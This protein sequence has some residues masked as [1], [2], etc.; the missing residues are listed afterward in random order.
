M[1]GYQGFTYVP[2]LKDAIDDET[3]SKWVDVRGRTALAFYISSAGTTSSGVVTLEE[4]NYV[5]DPADASA[6][7]QLYDGTPGVIATVN[8]SDVSGGAMSSVKAP[9]GAYA[10]VRARV[11]TVIGGGGSIS[12]GLVAV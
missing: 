3:T 12:V 7:V 6:E 8:A 5:A 9:I 4:T 10:F 1:S 2:L 11:S